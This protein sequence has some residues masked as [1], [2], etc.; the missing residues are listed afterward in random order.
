[1][2]ADSR[3]EHCMIGRKHKP[4]RRQKKTRAPARPAGRKTLAIMSVVFDFTGKRVFITGGSM[5]IGSSLVQAFCASGASVAFTYYTHQAAA[6][7]LVRLCASLRPDCQVHA[8]PMN[9]T[10]AA[11]V[12]RQ[13]QAAL[14]ALC[15]IDIGTSGSHPMDVALVLTSLILPSDPMCV[16]VCACVRL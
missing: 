7:D 8:L 6:E 4:T 10:D 5:G 9:L 14:T 12:D 11:D 2:K 16:Y 1:M 13:T 3:A 15:G